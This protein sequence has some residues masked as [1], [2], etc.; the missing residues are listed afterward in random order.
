MD[1]YSLSIR[2]VQSFP[3]DTVNWECWILVHS[4]NPY[5]IYS[6]HLPLWLNLSVYF[7]KIRVITHMNLPLYLLRVSLKISDLSIN[8][9][10]IYLVMCI[11]LTIVLIQPRQWLLSWL[12]DISK[13][14]FYIFL[15]SSFQHWESLFS[16]IKHYNLIS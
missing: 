15:L 13:L 8:S 12:R 5:D 1:M 16:A 4:F 10:L 11:L 7:Y 6:S 3:S 9:G 14:Y 2:V